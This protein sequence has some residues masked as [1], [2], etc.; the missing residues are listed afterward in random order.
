[1]K[2]QLVQQIEGQLHSLVCEDIAAIELRYALSGKV[3]GQHLREELRGQPGFIGLAGPMWGG[4]IEGEPCVR[5]EDAKA[6]EQ[7]SA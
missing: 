1:M 4:M 5:Y 7:L 6:Y 2:Y 3:G